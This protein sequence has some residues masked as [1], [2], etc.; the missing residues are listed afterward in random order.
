[1]SNKFHLFYIF[2]L[3][4]FA[5]CATNPYHPWYQQISYS[6]YESTSQCQSF[7]VNSDEEIKQIIDN[8]YEVIGYS[9]FNGAIQDYQKAE[10][11][12]RKIGADIV[13]MKYDYTNTVS[14][15][16][17]IPHYNPGQTYTVTSNSYGS[18]NAYGYGNSNIYGSDGSSYYGNY[19]G[20]AYGTYNDH[21]TT[22]VTT[23]GTVSYNNM[24]YSVQRYDQMA[25]FLKKNASTKRT[26]P[27][28][29]NNTQKNDNT[30]RDFM[31]REIK[32]E[33][34]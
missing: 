13:L 18:A 30:Y 6:N 11:Y 23:P 10:A 3:I 34:Q 26:T 21:T 28:Y 27:T 8:G 31:G 9:S 29:Q 24:P 20:N 22:Q 1:M 7:R 14:G 32:I 2:F 33:S 16:V 12:G 19:S 5:G 4:L 17:A 15:T 25:I